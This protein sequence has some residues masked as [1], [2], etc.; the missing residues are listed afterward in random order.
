MIIPC[1]HI[2]EE[3]V[4]ASGAVVTGDVPAWCIY[5]SVPAEYIKDRP[6]VKYTLNTKIK[7]LFR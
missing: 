1:V 5:S 6:V 4:I 7:D 3:A 2:H